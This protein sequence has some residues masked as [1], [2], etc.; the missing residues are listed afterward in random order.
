[1]AWSWFRQSGIL[2]S[3]PPAGNAHRWAAS[4]DWRKTMS[5]KEHI[6]SALREQLNNWEELLGQ[7]SD[8][9]INVSL[10]PSNWTAKD[11]VS[12][13]STWQQRSIA[14]LEASLSDREPVF[15]KW[16]PELDPD[17]EGG[18]DRINAWIYKTYH[19]QPWPTVQQDWRAG[20]LRFIE[21]GE[22]ISERDMIDESRYTWMGIRPLALVL[23][24][25]Y[26]H[27]QEHYDKLLAWL[28]EQ[29][30]L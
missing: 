23:I 3:H 27:H 22:R 6:L 10:T 8:N 16:L 21:L 30:E 28:K 2:S 14:R 19:D 29:S 4:L 12:H 17:S 15:P 5:M 26:D 7:L 13:L 25:S 11:V 24:S 18:T 1:M 9:Q 20:Y